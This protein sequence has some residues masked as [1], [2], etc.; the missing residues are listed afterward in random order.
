[1]I[2]QVTIIT[3]TAHLAILIPLIVLVAHLRVPAIT[4]LLVTRMKVPLGMIIHPIV[5]VIIIALMKMN[6][7]KIGNYIIESLPIY[8]K[9][10]NLY[11]FN[12]Y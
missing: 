7:T 3:N 6:D 4:V 9:N 2:I 10:P 1:M 12:I 8:H 11:V 5:Q